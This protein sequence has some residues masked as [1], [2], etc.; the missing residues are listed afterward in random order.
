MTACRFGKACKHANQRLLNQFFAASGQLGAESMANCYAAEARF[1][2]EV[3]S[4]QGQAEVTAMW[5]VLWVVICEKSAE[6]WALRV[7]SVEAGAISGHALWVTDYRFSAT[8]R[9]VHNVIDCGFEFNPVGQ[10]LRQHD[11]F[12]PWTW[13]GQ[14]LGVPG[15][16]LGWAPFMRR[17]IRSPAAANLQKFIARR[18]A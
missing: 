2:D 9:M 4:L 5:R 15:L 12:D 10:I 13:S 14:A 3:F 11:K 7:G 8:G 6:V 17:K 16:L 1:E 18:G